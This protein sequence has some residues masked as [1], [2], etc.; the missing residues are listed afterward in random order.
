[1]DEDRKNK[2]KQTE[3]KKARI[4]VGATRNEIDIS[5]LEWEAIQAGAIS[6][7]RLEKII[8]NANPDRL[9]QLA[10][11]RQKATLSA[12]K[13]SRIK[14]MSKSGYTTDEIAKH[15][16]VSTSTVNKYLN[17]KES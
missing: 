10:M 7:T 6:H 11:P 1:M 14:S 12:S 3:L 4:K 5:D 15:L 8:E 17:G 9:R 16:G 13:V 2:L